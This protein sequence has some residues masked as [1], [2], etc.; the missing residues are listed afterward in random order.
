MRGRARILVPIAAVLLLATIGIVIRAR[1]APRESL[2]EIAGLAESG[3]LD[4]AEARLVRLLDR[5]PRD[6]GANLLAAQIAMGRSDPVTRSG[7]GPD[8]KPARAA[9]GYLA[10]VGSRNPKLAALSGLWRG[11]AQRHLGLL[12]EAEESWLEALRLD[13]TVPEAGWLLLQ[14]YYLQGRAEEARELAVRLHEIE[15]D[16]RDRVLLL[17]EPLRQDVMPPAPASLVLWFEP[18]T[19]QS[20]GDV[21]ANI[22]LGLALVRS[23]A[24]DRGLSLLRKVVEI[25][26]GREEAWEALQRGLDESGD[27]EELSK[28]LASLPDRFS[29]ASWTFRYKARVEEERGDW[30]AATGN[31]RRALG[32]SPA[33]SRLGYRLAR[34]LRRTG[35]QAEADR[36]DREHQAREALNLEARALYEAAIADQSLGTTPQPELFG[37]LASLRERM[38]YQEQSRAWKRLAMPTPRGD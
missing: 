29:T 28:T 6:P 11:K 16:G 30:A 27:I 21:R 31:Y 25:H 24:V 12:E 17:L 2:A 7:I 36:L 1:L 15:P 34:S 35:E 10:R 37:K 23:S 5:E 8:P 33:D 38:G 3:R 18:I 14:E 22:A 13:P 9:L 32:A 26:P 19:S 20:P 4:D